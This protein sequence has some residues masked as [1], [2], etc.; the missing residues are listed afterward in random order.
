MEVSSTGCQVLS[1]LTGMLAL[2]EEITT[3]IVAMRPAS[4]KGTVNLSVVDLQIS[5][6]M[7]HTSHR[8]KM[9]VAQ[10][11]YACSEF[12]SICAGAY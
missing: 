1:T 2:T 4:A 9:C 6:V 12:N 7:Q 10:V 8:C 3:R 5:P 11:P